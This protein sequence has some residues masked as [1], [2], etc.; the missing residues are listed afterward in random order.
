MLEDN[1]SGGNQ[2]LSAWSNGTICSLVAQCEG[3]R[4]PKQEIN[5]WSLGWEDPLEK[6]TAA[7]SSILA[8]EIPWT[9]EPVGYS[10]WGCK[11]AGDDFVTK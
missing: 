10:S 1:L 2:E 7:H 8:W 4:L 5:V 6:E 9:E 11:R 3:T